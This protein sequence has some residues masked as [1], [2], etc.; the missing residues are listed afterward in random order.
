MTNVNFYDKTVRELT[1]R[2]H[3]ETARLGS[4]VQDY[5]MKHLWDAQEDIRSLKTLL[6]FGIRGMAAY[7]CHAAVLGYRSEEVQS[8]FYRVL[9]ALGN[10][11]LDRNDLLPLVMETGRVNLICMELLDRARTETSGTTG[12]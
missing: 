4:A 8:F 9:I 2:I 10:D 7:A 11:S 3:G 5:N 6:L 1:D 12:K